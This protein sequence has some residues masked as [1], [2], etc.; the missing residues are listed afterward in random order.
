[1]AKNGSMIWDCTG[2]DVNSKFAPEV[3][4]QL[5]A[6][7]KPN[8]VALIGASERAGSVSRTILLN[9]LVTPFGGGVFPVNPSRDKVLGIKAYKVFSKRVRATIFFEKVETEA[10]KALKLAQIEMLK[11]SIQRR[12]NLLSNE[13]YVTK[14]PQNIVEQERKNLALEEEKLKNLELDNK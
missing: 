8:N 6:I 1:M 9:L 10:D 4:N 13:G 2:N 14:A 7:F 3:C 12:K 11:K 5:D